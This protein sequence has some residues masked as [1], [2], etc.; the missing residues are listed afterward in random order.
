MRIQ[1]QLG[2]QHQ[3]LENEEKRDQ[4]EQICLEVRVKENKRV[5]LEA[6]QKEEIK[7]QENESAP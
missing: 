4:Q 7:T 1:G 2:G 5:Q 6:G 3:E